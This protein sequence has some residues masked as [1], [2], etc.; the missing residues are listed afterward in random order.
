[1]DP[2]NRAAVEG[3]LGWA[4]VVY[5]EG[6]K[7]SS[8]EPETQPSHGGLQCEGGDGGKQGREDGEWV[9]APLVGTCRGNH[10]RQQGMVGGH[11]IFRFTTTLFP[12][13]WSYLS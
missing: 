2:E 5:R 10:A 3:N 7:G 13:A 4:I 6:G 9:G 11:G 1:M 8:N 12:R